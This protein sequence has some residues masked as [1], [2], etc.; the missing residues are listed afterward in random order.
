[1]KYERQQHTVPGAGGARYLVLLSFILILLSSCSLG[2]GPSTGDAT[3]TVT[4]VPGC[5]L[6]SPTAKNFPN[7][8][9]TQQLLLMTPHPLR[10][11]YSLAQRLKLHTSSPIPQVVRTTPLNAHLGQEDAFWLNNSDSHT[12]SRIHA[13]LVIPHPTSTCMSKMDNR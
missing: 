11:L 6:P 8:L 4:Q 1:M 12:Y 13:K 7:L 3:P 9:Q 10:N 2:G 5:N